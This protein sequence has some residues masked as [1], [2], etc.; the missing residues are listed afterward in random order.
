M[1]KILAVTLAFVAASMASDGITSVRSATGALP[2]I[3]PNTW[4]VI[5]GTGIVPVTTPAD[6]VLLAEGQMPTGIGD[7]SVAVNNRPAFVYFYCS[8]ATSKV[9]TQDQINVLTPLDFA[10]GPVEVRV[11]SVSG[12]FSFTVNM[13]SLAPGLFQF[14]G[15]PNVWAVHANGAPVGPPSSFPEFSSPAAPNERIALY[16]N[17][18][19]EVVPPLTNGSAI[20]NGALPQLPEIQ[21]GGIPVTAE[22]A[23]LISP[24]LFQFNVLVPATAP[25][26][27]LAISVLYK[28][29][30]TQN[31][32]VILVQR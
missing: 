8:A 26:G 28:G 3:A 11:M 21:I 24:G 6:G 16:G 23:G 20:Q 4:T 14:S 10:T 19:G 30:T 13:Q 29:T 1:I 12:R 32:V 2:I 18:F 17:G 7:L 22:F 31:G 15:T 27:Y 5:T 25:S 9:C